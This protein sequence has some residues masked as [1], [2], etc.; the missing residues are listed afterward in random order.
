VI[1]KTEPDFVILDEAQKIKNFDTI[2]ARNIKQLQRKHALVIT[3][4]RADA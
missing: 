1:N 3:G 4:T 2:T